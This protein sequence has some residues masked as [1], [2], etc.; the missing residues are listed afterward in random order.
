MK[1]YTFILLSAL[2]LFAT[3]VAAQPTP[4]QVL[5]SV[6]EVRAPGK[7]FVFNVTAQQ[8]G[9]SNAT[10]F[11]LE[12]MVREST[13]SLVLYREPEKWNGRAMLLDGLDAFIYT[14]GTSRALRIS[15]AQQMASGITHADVARVVFSIDYS[16]DAV[17]NI[18]SSEGQPLY[19][20]D[21][22]AISNK[23]TYRNITLY[24]SHNYEPVKAEFFGISGKL[25]RTA[26]YENYQ[27]VLGKMRPMGIRLISSVSSE[28][29]ALLIYT[30]MQEKTTPA[31]YYQP[32]YLNQI[33]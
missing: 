21:L 26:Y 25:L 19:K 18:L 29:N 6:D 30:N 32:S 23:N 31:H 5:D 13:K 14:P 9:K 1:R 16:A 17:E 8:T 3:P 11:F 4:Q 28:E 10:E 27:M 12:T 20:L 2:M 33:R 22:T 24:C 7:N 15:P